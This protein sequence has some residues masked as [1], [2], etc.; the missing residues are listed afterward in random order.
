M[1]ILDIK[2]MDDWYKVTAQQV[3]DNGGVQAINVYK[4]VSKGAQYL[5]M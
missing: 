2:S 1:T 5:V 3:K 4:S